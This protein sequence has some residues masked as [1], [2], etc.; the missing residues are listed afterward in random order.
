MDINDPRFV[1]NELKP[2]VISEIENWHKNNKEEP[3]LAVVESVGAG[4]VVAYY[5][6]EEDSTFDVLNPNEIPCEIGDQIYFAEVGGNKII[7]FRK[8]I[9]LDNIYVDFINGTDAYADNNG[10]SYGT[11]THPFKTLQYAINRLPKIS[12]RSIIIHLINVYSSEEVTISSF[13]NTRIQISTSSASVKTLLNIVILDFNGWLQI[14]N[15]NV[16]NI[17]IINSSYI[18]I[19]NCILTRTN[20]ESGITVIYDSTAHIQGCTISNRKEI[21]F[22]IGAIVSAYG[23]TVYSVN[24]TGSNNGYGLLAMHCSVIGK[25]GSQPSGDANEYA[26]S[27]SEIRG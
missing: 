13:S 15:V 22:P 6:D 4:K 16:D 25:L 17:N 21:M 26:E 5:P 8:T 9:N 3:K 7:S 14:Y 1:T 2:Y 23:S 27:G 11:I 12:K 18:M 24:N 10:N 20:N 19:Y